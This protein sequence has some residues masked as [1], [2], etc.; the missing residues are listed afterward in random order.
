MK[1]LTLFILIG[2]LF[3]ISAWGAS[4]APTAIE[5]MRASIASD[6][7]E[8]DY[9]AEYPALSHDGRIIVFESA[10]A[11]LVPNDTNNITD[12]FMH[13]QQ[14]GQ[15][16]R[17]SISTTGGDPNW[18]SR[19]PDISAD[20]TLIVYESRAS[21]LV[22]GI[23]GNQIYLYNRQLMTTTVVSVASDGTQGNGFSSDPA[24]SANGRFI[25]FESSAANLVADD[26]NGVQDIFVHDRQTGQTARVS[27]A[28][29]GTE[30]DAISYDADISSD[31]RYVTYWSEATNLVAND[32]NYCG[33]FFPNCYDVFRHDRDT[34]MDGIFDEPGAIHTELVAVTPTGVQANDMTYSPAISGDGRFIAFHT[35]ATNLLGDGI[36]GTHIYVRDMLTGAIERVSVSSAGVAGNGQSLVSS[37]S[38][39]G[40]YVAFYSGAFNLVPNDTGFFFDVFIHDREMRQTVRASVDSNGVQGNGASDQVAISGNGEW[41]AY[42]SRASNLIADDTNNYDDVFA[43]FWEAPESSAVTL[44]SMHDASRNHN[45]LIVFIGLVTLTSISR[46]IAQGVKR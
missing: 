3:V 4:A 22:D 9:H 32:N 7:T 30:A 19:L 45:L 8:S 26:T 6:N 46:R 36:F 38:A 2:G 21:N 11:N 31:G 10:A 17:V 35:N 15:T 12:I 43:H 16:E 27:L 20:G 1:R 39:D 42:R 40:R 25:A 33:S 18:F 28:D 14:T 44:K 24:I 23:T 5:T 34:D 37:I 13:D 41:V 29:D